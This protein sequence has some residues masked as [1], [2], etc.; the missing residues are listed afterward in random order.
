MDNAKA[1]EKREQRRTFILNERLIKVIFVVAI[2]QVINMIIDSI[3]NMFDAFFVSGIGEAAIAA[4][5]VNDS[6]MQI[7]RSISVGFGM[8]SASFISRSLG[9]KKDEEASKAA[10]TTIFTAVVVLSIFA[11]GGLIFIK[12]LV[13]LLGATPEMFDYS[14]EYASWILLSAPITAATICLSQV[15]RSEGS[16]TF[17]MIGTVS[18]NI[19][20]IIINPIMITKMGWGVAGAAISTDIAK[21]VTLVILLIPFI[22][23]RTIVQLRWSFF[24]PTKAIYTEISKMGIPTML[25][26]GMFSVATIIMNNV[27]VGFGNAAVA[28]VVIA[29]KSLKMVASAVMGFG[30]GFQPIAGYSYGA[31]KYDRVIRAFIYTLVIGAIIGSILGIGLSIFVTPIIGIFSKDNEVHRLG[32]LLIYSQ[33]VSMVP[34][35]WVM[36]VTGLF[37]SLG[38]AVKAATLGLSRQLLILIPSILIL[39]RLF[40]VTGLTYAQATSDFISCT[41]AAILV[42]PVIKQLINL[43]KGLIEVETPIIEID[44]DELELDD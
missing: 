3:Y 14:I 9:A 23:R 29:N 25:R 22:K 8:G 44:Y 33:S 10:V 32:M 35:V 38:N 11:I 31:K 5:G 15:L 20:D 41:L 6:L 16:T 7:M 27:A 4:V 42:I 2:P 18:G 12:P 21:V 37:Q 28:A 13:R 30:Q 17:A 24:T 1:A 43:N 40:G 34:H 39:S 26:T 19:F 36:I